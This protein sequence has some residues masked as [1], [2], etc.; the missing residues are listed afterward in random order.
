VVASVAYLAFPLG[1]NM[2]GLGRIDVLFVIAGLPLVVR[3]LFELLCVPGF[4]AGPYPAPVPFGHE[5]WRSTEAGQRM[6]A[7]M[8]IALITAMAPATLVLVVLIVAGVSLARFFE[9]DEFQRRVRPWR[10][11]GSLGFNVAIFLLPMTVDFFLAGRRAFE[12]F[13]LSRGPWSSPS[14]A[15][16]FRGA[17]GTFGANWTG[18]LL[19]GAAVLALVLCRDQ[20]RA[21]ASKV[22]TIATLTL[23]LA[24]LVSHHWLGSFAPDLDVLLSLYAV[25]IALLIGLGVSALELDLRQ[26][27]FGWRQ[28]L[29]SLSVA[30]IVVTIVPLLVSFSSGRFDL[31]TT[32]VAESLSA[33]APPNAGGYRVLWLGDPSVMPLPG[34]SVAPGL[35]AATSTNGLPSGDT[36][37]SAP[38][39]G[40]TDK[41][42]SAVKS[43]VAGRTVRLGQLL[44]PAGISTIVV[45]NA[46]AP[47]LAGVQ[48]VPLHPVPAG[49][50]A[51]LGLQTDLSL[52]LQT[53]SVVVFA[54]SMYRGLVSQSVGG[55]I[56]STHLLASGTTSSTV[57]AGSTVR[58]GVAPASDF[59]LVVNGSLARRSVSD[60]WVPTFHV[61]TESPT[62]TA[63]LVLHRFPWNGILAGITLGLWTIVWLGFGLVQRL[64]WLFTGRRRRG[65]VA[66]HARKTDE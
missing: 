48:S 47:E 12:V 43:A 57:S 21:I 51:A 62:G 6:A 49:L 40:T 11:L 18:W 24:T 54:N 52:E 2:I 34:W 59:S 45:M 5:G 56:T 65:V 35:E 39:S 32:S 31:P 1:V 7:I 41:I 33:L 63:R 37:F 14:F 29:A 23:V 20:R 22:A 55:T 50:T 13:G 10:L 26:S 8:L 3:R 16:L 36:L 15:N 46:S 17:D 66:R 53:S 58:A 28:V 42:L 64:E 9:G 61:T 44:A 60:G 25:M 27:G 30:T 19:P 38:D 4:R